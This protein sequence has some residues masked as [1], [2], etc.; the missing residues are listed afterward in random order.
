MIT[1]WNFPLGMLAR[2]ISPALAAGCTAVVKPS[3]DTPL[4]ALAFAKLGEEAGVPAGV[5]NI[6]TGP[7][8]AAADIG[9]TLSADKDVRKINMDD[10]Y[11]CCKDSWEYIYIYISYVRCRCANCP[12]QGPRRSGS[13]SR[14][15]APVPLS[16]SPSSWVAMLHLSSLMTQI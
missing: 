10:I 1:P 7:R 12:L 9:R 4:S 5:I 16:E 3:E 2:K 13:Y 14:P 11:V 15:I 6:V 8:E